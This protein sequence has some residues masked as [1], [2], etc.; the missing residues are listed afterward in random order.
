MR[1]VD[2]YYL[3]DEI[4]LYL[5]HENKDYVKTRLRIGELG[6]KT[7]IFNDIDDY[8]YEISID[9]IESAFDKH[10]D[11]IIIITDDY[12]LGAVPII[13]TNSSELNVNYEVWKF[14][15]S[16]ELD[17]SQSLIKQGIKLRALDVL[18]L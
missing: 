7:F 12:D 6:Y 17:F 13:L 4:K 18:F 15:N 5:Y 16:F 3:I 11:N 2:S 8:F 9:L 10:Y 14:L 1:L